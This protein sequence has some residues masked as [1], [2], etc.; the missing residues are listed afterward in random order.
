MEG[1]KR[2][3]GV[4]EGVLG[5]GRGRGRGEGIGG[6]DEGEGGKKLGEGKVR[7]EL[8]QMLDE[9]ISG[10]WAMSEP[11]SSSSSSSLDLSRVVSMGKYMRVVRRFEVW[12]ER[13][14]R[15]LE[16]R[17]RKAAEADDDDKL[18]LELDQNGEVEMIG[19]LDVEW[20]NE[21]VA[22]GRRLEEWRRMLGELSGGG[23]SGVS[24]KQPDFRASRSIHGV[25]EDIVGSLEMKEGERKIEEAEQEEDKSTPLDRILSGFASL[26]NNML[27]ELEIMGQIEREA[28]AEESE[29]VKRMNRIGEEDDGKDREEEVVVEGGESVVK[30]NDRAGAIWRVF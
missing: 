24:W 16:G 19:S 5:L 28:V 25:K 18:K 29:W 30:K 26:V 27:A 1:T 8:I 6:S 23:G 2:E 9:V 10:V 17:R 3:V 15:I 14:G 12:A 21:C 11:S 7:E 22:L 20:K 4:V 13:A